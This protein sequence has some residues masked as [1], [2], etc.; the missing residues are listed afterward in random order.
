MLGAVRHGAPWACAAHDF[1][2][3]GMLGHSAGHAVRAWQDIGL[4]CPAAC[5]ADDAHWLTRPSVLCYQSHCCAMCNAMQGIQRCIDIVHH[6][7]FCGSA[8]VFAV[9]L[10]VCLLQPPFIAA[11]RTCSRLSLRLAFHTWLRIDFDMFTL[12]RRIL[13]FVCCWFSTQSRGHWRHGRSWAPHQKHCCKSLFDYLCDHIIT[14]EA[15]CEQS[16]KQTQCS[17]ET[18]H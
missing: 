5:A 9:Y 3:R 10:R 16:G 2:R 13:C 6:H 7:S 1:G 8:F 11:H 12:L 4:A 14:D 15:S 17:S 18:A